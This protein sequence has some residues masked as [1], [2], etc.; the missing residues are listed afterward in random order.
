MIILWQTQ[1]SN[2][3]P[4]SSSTQ[5]LPEILNDSDLEDYNSSGSETSTLS[6]EPNVTKACKDNLVYDNS[7]IIKLESLSDS[8]YLKSE[9]IPLPSKSKRGFYQVF[10]KLTF[11]SGQS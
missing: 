6:F 2:K 4:S 3:S 1:L 5:S 8:Q 10:L 7:S 11:D 9:F